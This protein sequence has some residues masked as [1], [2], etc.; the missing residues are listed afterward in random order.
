MSQSISKIT[1]DGR[2]AT[3]S[4]AETTL[5]RLIEIFSKQ[6]AELRGFA[7]ETVIIKL[8]ERQA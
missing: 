5:M 4:E 3:G 6:V 2:A 7:L 1:I 8:K